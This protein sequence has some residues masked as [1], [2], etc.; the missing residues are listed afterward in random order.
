MLRL[1]L[2]VLRHGRTSRLDAFA[3]QMSAPKKS[4]PKG[5]DPPGADTGQPQSPLPEGEVIAPPPVGDED[6][7]TKAPNPEAGHEEEVIPPPAPTPE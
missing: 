3:G 2:I 4:A 7:Y 1:Y 6:I 5:Q